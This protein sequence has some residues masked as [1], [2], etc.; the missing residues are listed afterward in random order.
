MKTI[1]VLP[2]AGLEGQALHH[3]IA[4]SKDR[5]GPEELLVVAPAL[6]SRL[7]HW[8]SDEDEARRDAASRLANALDT[9]RAAGVEAT[10]R[11]GDADPVQAVADALHMFPANTIVIAAEHERRPHW[12]MRDLAERVRDRFPQPVTQVG[13]R[14][15]ASSAGNGSLVPIHA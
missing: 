13:A 5:G 1:V 2:S 3:V 4:L 8:C 10:G 11:V 7:R 12:L 6:N 14:P 9:L 15:I